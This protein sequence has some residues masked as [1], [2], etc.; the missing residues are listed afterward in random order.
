MYLGG[1]RAVLGSAAH[2]QKVAS[3]G[4]SRRFLIR[5]RGVLRAML[6]RTGTRSRAEMKATTTC[7]LGGLKAHYKRGRGM[8]G[9]R[10]R[11]E[12]KKIIIKT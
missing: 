9:F 5:I 4:S 1:G 12:R 10:K 3:I 6:R 7:F 8:A 2:I 11:K